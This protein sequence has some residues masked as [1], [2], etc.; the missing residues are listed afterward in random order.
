M[1]A[2]LRLTKAHGLGNDFLVALETANPGLTAAAVAAGGSVAATALCDRH[3][4][5]GADGLIFGLAPDAPGADLRMVLFNA[6][7][8]EAEISGN[9]IRCLG[10]AALRAGGRRDGRIVIDSGAGRRTLDAT[11]TTAPDTDLLRVEMGELGTGPEPGPAAVAMGALH[12]GS[13]AVGNPHIVL[14]LVSLDGV[15][16]SVEG[17]LIEADVPGGVNVHFLAASGPDT[18]R[19]LHWERGAGVTEACGSG[20][21]VSAALAHRW[22]LVGERVTVE[23][24]GGTAVVD[25]GPTLALTGEAVHIADIEVENA[26]L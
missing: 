19:L 22:G 3:R 20:A 2:S 17:P 21:S 10:Q 25:V 5:V 8:S 11:A 26:W 6:D 12:V 15:D 4:G 16:P 13:G 14:H 1:T 18:I 9:G 23:M 24:P 7:G